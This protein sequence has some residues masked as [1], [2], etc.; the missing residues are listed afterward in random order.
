MKRIIIQCA[1]LLCCLSIYT[2]IPG[3]H[4]SRKA[5]DFSKLQTIKEDETLTPPTDEQVSPMPSTSRAVTPDKKQ[6]QQTTLQTFVFIG[7]KTNL[8]QGVI[9]QA[10]YESVDRENKSLAPLSPFI[11]EKRVASGALQRLEFNRFEQRGHGDRKNYFKL[12]K[13]QF[14][15]QKTKDLLKEMLAPELENGNFFYTEFIAPIEPPAP[16]LSASKPPRSPDSPSTLSLG[17]HVKKQQRHSKSMPSS[18]SSSPANTPAIKSEGATPTPV[19]IMPPYAPSDKSPLERPTHDATSSDR[20]TRHDSL[21]D[22]STLPE[23]P[24]GDVQ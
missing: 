21:R 14:F 5:D 8:P 18:L 4:R 12:N 23:P 20:P 16:T 9:V 24:P 19:F 11:I 7:V 6:Q 2:F 13:I 1:G 10:L 15:N 17:K 22:L 3:M